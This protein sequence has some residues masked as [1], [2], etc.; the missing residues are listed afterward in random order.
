MAKA[1]EATIV[2]WEGYIP[3]GPD[4]SGIRVFKVKQ[5]EGATILVT[6]FKQFVATVMVS[7]PSWIIKDLINVLAGCF[8]ERSNFRKKV[9]KA[10]GYDKRTPLAA[11]YVVINRTPLVIT[12]VNA[13]D[14]DKLYR[15]WLDMKELA[16][17]I[18]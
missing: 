8:A 5:P 17:P 9:C 12:K 3:Q 16:L 14:P 7:T 4:C 13:A 15:A 1:T 10:Y 6:N 2:S 18:L 11:I